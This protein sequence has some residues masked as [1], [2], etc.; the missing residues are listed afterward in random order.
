MAEGVGIGVGEVVDCVG[1]YSGGFWG[2][3]EMRYC[4]KGR[5]SF[6]LAG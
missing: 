5:L 2:E 3:E 1:G 4:I 6:F